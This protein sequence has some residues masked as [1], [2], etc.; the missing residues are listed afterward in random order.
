MGTSKY[1]VD[2]QNYRCVQD[3]ATTESPTSGDGV[4]GGIVVDGNWPP[5][6]DTPEECCEDDL[7]YVDPAFCLDNSK[8]TSTG[9]GLYFSDYGGYCVKDTDDASCT[10]PEK[11]KRATVSNKPLFDSVESCCSTAHASNNQEL[12]TTRSAGTYTNKWFASFLC[13]Q[14]CDPLNS[15]G[16]LACGEVSSM[17]VELFPDAAGCCNEKLSWFQGGLEECV[18]P[19]QSCEQ[20]PF[21]VDETYHLSVKVPRLRDSHSSRVFQDC[22]AQHSARV[23]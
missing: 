8:A 12:C 16:S 18:A 14:D 7:T 13:M 2:S 3:C 15:G 17:N 5:L 20:M 19:S 11:C 1:Y 6:R 10:S 4:C 23:S 9:T 22:E 21:L